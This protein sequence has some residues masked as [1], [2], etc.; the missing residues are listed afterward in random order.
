MPF[1]VLRL[2]LRLAD[3]LLRPSLFLPEQSDTVRQEDGV[4][5]YAKLKVP[6]LFSP[7]CP[8][9]SI[10]SL[11]Y[12]IN[13]YIMISS[14]KFYI[15]VTNMLQ[16]NYIKFTSCPAPPSSEHVWH[17]REGSSES[18]SASDNGST[19]SP[20]TWKKPFEHKMG[21]LKRHITL[22]TGL[23]LLRSYSASCISSPACRQLYLSR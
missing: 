18:H 15:D 14:Y 10:V 16:S 20:W 12:T 22:K 6:R 23:K 7:R 5:S 17:Q 2:L 13:Y 21:H 1:D 19:A 11:L 8:S 9:I 4:L 3:L